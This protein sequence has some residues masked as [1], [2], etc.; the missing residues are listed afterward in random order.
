MLDLFNQIVLS[1]KKY[2]PNAAI[3]WDISPWIGQDGM[4]TWW[5]YFSNLSYIDFIHT[6]GGV[7]TG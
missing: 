3:S 2:L 4:K 6:S 7:N 1:I 5:Y